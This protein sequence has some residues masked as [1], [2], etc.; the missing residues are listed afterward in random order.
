MV[1][2]EEFHNIKSHKIISD[3]IEET[4]KNKKVV[5]CK[6]YVSHD[7]YDKHG[8]KSN[9]YDYYIIVNEN[10]DYI[11]YSF[12][13]EQWYRNNDDED[14]ELWEMIPL[15]KI[16]KNDFHMFPEIKL[17]CDIDLKKAYD[18]TRAS[19]F[20]STLSVSLP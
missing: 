16:T 11:F 9:L 13:K 10:D 17:D 12:H 2:K 6:H 8:P 4:L 5:Y 19:L 7:G 18:I 1:T 15:S 14:F 3:F 20:P